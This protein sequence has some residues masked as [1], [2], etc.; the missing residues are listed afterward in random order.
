MIDR[1]RVELLFRLHGVPCPTCG[2]PA[3]AVVRTDRGTATAHYANP[4]TGSG[5]ICPHPSTDQEV[6]G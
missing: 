5:R 3:A 4:D 6:H 1:D 2:V